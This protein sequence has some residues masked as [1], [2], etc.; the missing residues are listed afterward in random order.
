MI[1]RSKV[2]G[3]HLEDLDEMAQTLKRFGRYLNP[4]RCVPKVRSSGLLGFVI[5]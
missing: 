1:K 3:A 5:H 4:A 2:I